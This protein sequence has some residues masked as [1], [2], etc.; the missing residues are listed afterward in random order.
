MVLEYEIIYSE[1]T[2]IQFSGIVLKEG[3]WCVA[4]GCLWDKHVFAGDFDGYFLPFVGKQGIFITF[5]VVTGVFKI[6]GV[7][8]NIISKDE[9]G[10][11]TLGITDWFSALF[12]ICTERRA[13]QR[14][15]LG[16]EHRELLGV[17]FHLALSARVARHLSDTAGGS[18]GGN[19]Y[20][21]AQHQPHST[22][23]S[24]A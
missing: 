12:A 15:E 18:V 4:K 20:P 13:G 2:G 9:I 19:L 22:Y 17:G 8:R 5:Y 21:G 7:N 16:G 11:I 1:I 14:A 6:L 23:G 3:I 24:P 10:G